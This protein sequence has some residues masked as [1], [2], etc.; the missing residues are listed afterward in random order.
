[1]SEQT[2]QASNILEEA[3][4]LTS[5]DRREEYGH[6]KDNFDDIATMWTAILHTTVTRLEVI[7]CMIALKLCRARQGYKRDT[8]VDIAGYARCAEMVIEDKT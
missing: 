2:Q 3:D 6:P 1:M 8:Y 5:Q 4:K 7:N